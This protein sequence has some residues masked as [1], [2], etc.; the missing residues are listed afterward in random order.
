MGRKKFRFNL[1]INRNAIKL[2]GRKGK[3]KVQHTIDLQI[4]IECKLSTVRW[5]ELWLGYL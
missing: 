1:K 4:E 3:K 5:Y 2:S